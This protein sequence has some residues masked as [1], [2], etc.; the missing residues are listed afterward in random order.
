MTKSQIV[1]VVIF[2]ILIVALLSF[3]MA[4][5]V[6]DRREHAARHGK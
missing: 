6:R 4:S 3:F 5:I 2:A 1:A